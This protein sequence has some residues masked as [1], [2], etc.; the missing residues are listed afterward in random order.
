MKEINEK[1][2]THGKDNH[3]KS[4]KK[5]KRKELR[6]LEAIARQVTRIIKAEKNAQKAKDK[7]AAF[8]KVEH[9]KLTLLQIR[10]GKPHD[11]LHVSAV[12]PD[13]FKFNQ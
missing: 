3:N 13:A 12:P 1:E 5:A 2:N 4:G 9:A 11:Q 6:R 8:K 7:A 10:G